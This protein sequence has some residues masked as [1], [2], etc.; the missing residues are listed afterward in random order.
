MVFDDERRTMTFPISKERCDFWRGRGFLT[1][2]EIVQALDKWNF[3]RRYD[4]LIMNI[5]CDTWGTALS[6]YLISDWSD[7]DSL[8]SDLAEISLSHGIIYIGSSLYHNNCIG[9]AETPDHQTNIDA[10]VI[11]AIVEKIGGESGK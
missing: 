6:Q 5:I 10:D 3:D 11:D 7:M 9:V 1:K 4:I 8:I 2:D